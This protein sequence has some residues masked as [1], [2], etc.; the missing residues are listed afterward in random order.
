MPSRPRFSV[1]F[2]P[3]TLTH[4]AV[5]PSRHYRLIRSVIH[6]QLTYS[7]DQQTRNRKP[8]E[9]PAPY[10]A[11][12]E[13][14]FGPKNRFR[15]LYDIEPQQQVVVILAIGIKEGNRLIVGKQEFEL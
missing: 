8:L 15:V 12:W 1:I 9:P 6:E 10:N 7:P 11:A 2:A 13:L 3:E 14:R 4:L 5:I